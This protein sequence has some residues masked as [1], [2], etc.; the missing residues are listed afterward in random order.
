MRKAYFAGLSFPILLLLGSGLANAQP[1]TQLNID[2][3]GQVVPA[4]QHHHNKVGHKVTWARV[5]G[6]SKP[7]FVKF[8]AGSPCAEGNTLGSSSA[9]TCTIRVKCNA[10]GDPGCKSY[11]YKSAT[12]PNDP[13]HDPEIIVDP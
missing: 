7:W 5:S 9:K 10:A 8:T 11:P 12:G 13:P 4:H 2:D 6:S 3:T 1:P